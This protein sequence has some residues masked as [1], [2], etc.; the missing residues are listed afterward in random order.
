MFIFL[1]ARLY[2][3]PLLRSSSSIKPDI[4]EETVD[5]G[6]I[7]EPLPPNSKGKGKAAEEDYES[8]VTRLKTQEEEL[9]SQALVSF[10]N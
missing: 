8:R 10:W 3:S 4:R 1:A 7:Q 2:Q 9:R 5:L 6:W